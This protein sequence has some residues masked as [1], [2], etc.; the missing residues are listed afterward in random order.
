MHRDKSDARPLTFKST[1][2]NPYNMWRAEHL[3]RLLDAGVPERIAGDNRQFWLLVQ[4]GEEIGHEGW[5]VDWIDDDQALLLHDL[6]TQF[7]GNEGSGWDLICSL[8]R[9]LDRRQS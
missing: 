6:L 4:E 9:K 5:K 8:R 7:F 2:R 1:N 3:H